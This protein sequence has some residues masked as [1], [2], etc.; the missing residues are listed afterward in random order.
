[1]AV[2]NSRRKPADC[3]RVGP[4][5][6]TGRLGAP[7]FLFS[8]S[9][10]SRVDT[11]EMDKATSTGTFFPHLIFHPTQRKANGRPT[12]SLRL[13]LTSR[14][15]CLPVRL[16][17][18]AS[19]AFDDVSCSFARFKIYSLAV[20]VNLALESALLKESNLCIRPVVKCVK[21]A[22]DSAWSDGSAASLVSCFLTASL[23]F[24]FSDERHTTGWLRSIYSSGLG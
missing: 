23:C 1:M 8:G 19:C 6:K 2:P 3:H 13:L 4:Q 15:C 24:G 14:L 11:T 17:S 21:G 9:R 12:S 5:R 7:F 18:L 10:N 16:C 20:F 22:L